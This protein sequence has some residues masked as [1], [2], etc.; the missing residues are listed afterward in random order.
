MQSTIPFGCQ[1]GDPGECGVQVE[2]VELR[3]ETAMVAGAG[4]LEPLEVRVEVG[5]RVEGGPVDARELRV[6]LVAA[7]VR[8]GEPR[9]LQRLDRRGVLEVR[10]AA[11]IREV[12]LRVERDRAVGLL[13]ELDLVRLVLGLEARDRVQERGLLARP[14]AALR[15]LTPDLLLDRGEVVLGDRLGELEVVVEAVGDRRPDRDLHARVEAE[16]GLGEQVR[17]RV[18]E[19][20]QRV[21]VL[22][23]ARREDLDAL[24]VREREP[25]VARRAVRAQEDG[26]LGELGADRAGCVEPGRALGQLQLGGVRKHDLHRAGG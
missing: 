19:H 10:A 11:E 8:A 9:E 18:P 22:R 4:L 24:A 2:E 26:L 17:A 23:V 25:Q 6:L 20:R 15:D 21:L 16:D 3:A 12:P 5:L 1:N 14:R 13:R 7:P